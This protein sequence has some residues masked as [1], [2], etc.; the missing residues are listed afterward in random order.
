METNVT[1][2]STFET[3]CVGSVLR[4]LRDHLNSH[5][6]ETGL[7][8]EGQSRLLSR[9]LKVMNTAT[10]PVPNFT[11]SFCE[12]RPLYDGSIE[13]ENYFVLR[14]YINYSLYREEAHPI[15]QVIAN[16]EN[17]DSKIEKVDAE[18]I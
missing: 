11:I 13:T 6:S 1:D 3:E 2:I 16:D 8:L 10:V 7:D 9:L 14:H 18:S 15:S 4:E 17:V 5:T 12:E